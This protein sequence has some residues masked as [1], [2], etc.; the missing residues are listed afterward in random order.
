[1]WQRK[2]LGELLAHLAQRRQEAIRLAVLTMLES[3]PQYTA[4]SH[5][6]HDTLTDCGLALSQNDFATELAWLC[7]ENLIA[8]LTDEPP[9]QV[10]RLTAAGA[11]VVQGRAQVSGVRRPS[12]FQ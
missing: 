1:M 11:D 3:V 7:A 10:V 9:S 8:P 12:F 4:P 5:V 6:L 2:W